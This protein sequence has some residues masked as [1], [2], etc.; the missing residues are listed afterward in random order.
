MAALKL[1][2]IPLPLTPECWDYRHEPSHLA[3]FFCFVLSVFKTGIHYV[4]LVGL[5]LGGLPAWSP[6]CWGYRC[7]PPW[8]ALF[9]SSTFAALVFYGV[10]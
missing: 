6:E 7:V 4:A 5:E 8:T 10:M 3:G 2:E 9:L 1:T